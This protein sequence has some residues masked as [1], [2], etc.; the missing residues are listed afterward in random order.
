MFEKLME[1]WA[2]TARLGGMDEE[3]RD[4]LEDQDEDQDAAEDWEEK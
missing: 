3:I 1:K 2:T 4:E